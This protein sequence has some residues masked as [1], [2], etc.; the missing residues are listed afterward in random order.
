MKILFRFFTKT[1]LSF[2]MISGL[3]IIIVRAAVYLFE[4]DL[5]NFSYHLSNLTYN[6]IVLSVCL[7]FGTIAYRKKTTTNNLTYG[8]GLLLCI[9]I[10]FVTIFIILVYDIIFSVLIVPDYLS[11]ILDPQ[12]EAVNKNLSIPL[13]KKIEI[14]EKLQQIKSPYY[15][16]SM[17]ALM[18]FGLSVII[19]L[20]VAIFT[21]RKR[22][23]ANN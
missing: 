18:S 10:S 20:I 5:T 1:I 16:S 21:V 6:I 3:L 19:S 2:G 14:V 13:I 22:P 11:N 23:I 9:S 4:I 17:N 7:Y 12:I 8:K 15:N